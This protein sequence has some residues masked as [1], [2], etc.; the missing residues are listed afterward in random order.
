VEAIVAYA[1]HDKKN[2]GDVIKC[3]LLRGLGHGIFDQAVTLA[4]IQDSLRAYAA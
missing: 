2:R 3:T 4:E 1:L